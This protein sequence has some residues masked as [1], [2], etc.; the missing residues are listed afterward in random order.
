MWEES[1]ESEPSDDE[2]SR[3]QMTSS[4]PDAIGDSEVTTTTT[5]MKEK[6]QKD[7]LPSDEEMKEDV[8]TSEKDSEEESSS[9]DEGEKDSDYVESGKGRCLQSSIF[10]V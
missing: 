5:E 3:N 1:S 4:A 7:D 2:A 9:D 6:R 10:H 8:K